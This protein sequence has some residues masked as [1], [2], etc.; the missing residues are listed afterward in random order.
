ML[1]YNVC[2]Q[3]FVGKNGDLIDKRIASLQSRLTTTYQQV[4]AAAPAANI[5][6][7][8][9]PAILATWPGESAKSVDCTGMTNRIRAWLAPK[10]ATLNA[11][12]KKAAASVKGITVIDTTSVFK[13]HEVCSDT[14]TLNATPTYITDPPNI[15]GLSSSNTQ[16]RD[17][18]YHPNQAGQ[19]AIS[20][21][22]TAQGVK[23]A[24]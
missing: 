9:Y 10:A 7:L 16:Q 4:K 5:Y 6:V 13:G 12:V 19:Q 20:A 22:L 2:D 23:P 1:L 8:T 21:Y 14:R 11:V 3:N 15:V 24:P 18:W 17:N